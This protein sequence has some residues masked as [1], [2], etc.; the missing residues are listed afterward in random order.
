LE[1]LLGHGLQKNWQ[2]REVEKVPLVV[3]IPGRKLR[4]RRNNVTAAGLVDVPNTAAALL[5]FRFPM[6]FGDDLF[7]MKKDLPVIFRNGSYILGGALIEPSASSATDLRSGRKLDFNKYTAATADA[8]K[9][10]QYS[11]RVL[12]HDLVDAIKQKRSADN[13]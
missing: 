13:K 4:P 9:R 1:K 7:S 11:D 12:E 5:G 2:W 6:G 3:H 8:K 10:L